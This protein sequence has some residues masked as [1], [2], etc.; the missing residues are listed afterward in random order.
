MPLQKK[1]LKGVYISSLE[2]NWLGFFS[3]FKYFRVYLYRII[4]F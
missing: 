2:A 3:K 4:S 1:N